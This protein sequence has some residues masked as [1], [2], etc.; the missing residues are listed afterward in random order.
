M[1]T[2]IHLDSQLKE[3]AQLTDAVWVALVER[4][5][6]VWLMRASFRLSKSAQNE[7]I[8]LTAVAATD[9][10]M[11]GALIGR[12]VRSA[13]IPKNRFLGA[14]RF[15]A[16]PLRGET[17]LLLIGADA[18]Q[19][20]AAQRIWRLTAS[21]L[22]ERSDLET[23]LLSNLQ[24]DLTSNLPLALEKILLN[25]TRTVSCRGAWLAV[26]RGSSLDV[27]AEWNAPKARNASLT[28][29][30]NPVLRRLNRSL[31]DVALTAEQPNFD[32]LPFMNLKSGGAWICLPLALGRRLIGVV[33]MWRQK[34][35]SAAERG[36]LR[37]LAA[38]APQAVDVALAFSEMSAHLRRLGLLNDIALTVSSAQNLDQIA[39]RIF[40]LLAR[41]F[42]TELIALFLKFDD[43]HLLRDYRLQDEKLIVAHAS[44]PNR[45][46]APLLEES[47]ARRVADKTQAGFVGVY[48]SARSELALPLR[49]HGQT[50]GAL[51]V[52]N[53][54]PEAFSQYDENLMVVVASHLAGLIEYVRLREEAQGRARSLE[55]IHEVVQ[56]IIGLND[57]SEVAAIA[58]DLVA[59]DFH[60]ESVIISLADDAGEFSIRGVGGKPLQGV[61]AQSEIDVDIQDGE[62]ILGNVRASSREANAFS[63]NDFIAMEALAGILSSVTTSANQYQRL[64]ETIR[65]LQLTETE[66]NERIEAQRAAENRL[67]QAAKLAAVGEM[68]AG[69]AHEL[70]NPLTSVAGF[71]ELALEGL[72][73]DSPRRQD[74]LIV[75]QE[76]Q[77]AS[78]V[79]RRLLDFARQGERV[80]A[81]ADLN[82]V[83]RDVIALTRHL[84]QTSDVNLILELDETLP[85]ISIDSNQIKQVMLNL[86]HNALQAMPQGGELR[87]RTF[88]AKREN[89]N[90]LTLSVGDTG[91]GI[92][93][94]EQ[95][96]IFEPFFTT[97]GASGG[98]GLGLSVTYGI[99][100]DHDG[101]IELISAPA[102]GSTFEVWLPL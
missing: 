36:Q 25:F 62:R 91:V 51:I 61:E 34:E 70:N 48:E 11:C 89:K 90:G 65:Q 43:G 99:V 44:P 77:R 59:R 82:E 33:A 87:V 55:L 94:E 21:L 95:A 78:S 17:K 2:D 10:W 102:S 68:A 71:S 38:S 100:A 56:Q 22:S 73:E 16:Y 92:S 83:V 7:L 31:A 37:E 67:L 27:Q 63:R 24:P 8:G 13:A 52:E 60:Y 80:R 53:A 85:W 98:T 19:P 58:A 75:L 93:D 3:A 45:R 42:N 66:L 79:V 81:S 47:R 1:P 39:Q 40:N 29:E 18:E 64:Q 76:A 88:A 15:Y 86:I 84:I 6:G 97:K 69:V 26:R 57:K 30:D 72:P 14:R 74:L 50:I 46:L 4:V 23:P 5:G 35:F 20:S 28:I 49:Y 9:A 96:K 32:R 101:V 54:Q 12:H 41:S